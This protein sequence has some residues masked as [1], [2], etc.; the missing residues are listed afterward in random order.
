MPELPEV[1]TI[2]RELDHEVVGRR[3][4]SVD[5][6]PGSKRTLRRHKTS[7]EVVTRLEGAKITGVRRRGK[8]LLIDF[9]NGEVMVVHLGMSGQLLYVKATKTPVAKHTKLVVHFTQAGELRFIDPRTFG[10]VF[11]TK[12]DHMGDTVPE[13]AEL[14]FDPLVDVMS[15]IRF[16]S[17]LQQRSGKL[18]AVLM[19]QR[20]VAGI[21][22]LY[23]DE[24]LFAAGLRFDRDAG[25]LTTEE[26]RRLYRAML[27]TLNEAVK[28]RGSSLADEQY[29]DIF[30]EL[31]G[32]Q[33]SHA[34]YGREGKAC[35]RCRGVIIRVRTGGRSTY[36]CEQCQV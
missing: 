15:W 26:T 28:Q 14:G 35:L 23:A 31:G 13:L 1:E 20:F 4:K 8:Y 27:E 30:G 10:E 36:Y 19:D 5:A 17:L 3:V 29:K 6:L 34:V 12:G 22:N 11:V 21:G 32:Y 9:D 33:A 25:S 7:K 18:K 16:G 24:I 2:R